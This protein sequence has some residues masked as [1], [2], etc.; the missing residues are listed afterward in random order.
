MYFYIYV[1]TKIHTCTLDQEKK[2][3]RSAYSNS[4]QQLMLVI[5]DPAARTRLHAFHIEIHT[6][7]KDRQLPARCLTQLAPVLH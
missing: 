4:K 1:H 3:H 2:Q 5:L 7:S 6:W